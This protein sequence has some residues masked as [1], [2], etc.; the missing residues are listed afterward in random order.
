M[1]GLHEP[2]PGPQAAWRRTLRGLAWPHS[3]RAQCA[4]AVCVLS[5]LILA[6]GSTAIWALRKANDATRRLA[7]EQLVRMQAAQDLLQ[8]SMLVERETYRMLTNQS[9]SPLR[10]DD[11]G[12][13]AQLEALDHAVAG[14]ADASADVTVLDLYQSSQLFRNTAHIVVQLRETN[15]QT[16]AAFDQAVREQAALLQAQSS[17]AATRLALLL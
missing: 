11:A 12:I 16:A 6:A 4:L 14:L 10:Q 15:V 8:R 13:G 9:S 3:L 2:G 7:N 5:V 1:T 17:T